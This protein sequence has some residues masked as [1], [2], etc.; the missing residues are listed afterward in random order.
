MELGLLKAVVEACTYYMGVQ[1]GEGD[2][3]KERFLK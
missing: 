2:K 1:K 3:R